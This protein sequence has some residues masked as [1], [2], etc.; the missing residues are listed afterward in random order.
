MAIHIL[1][2]NDL[3]EHEES[4]TCE[5]SPTLEIENGEMIFIHNS[6]D[7]RE[8]VESINKQ[9]QQPNINTNLISDGYHTFDEL[10]EH[11][12]TLWIALCKIIERTNEF[13]YVWRT[14]LHSDGSK[15][16]GW[17]VLGIGEDKGEQ[18]TYHLPIGKWNECSFAIPIDKA[19]EFDGH[20]SADVLK[21]ISTLF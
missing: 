21:R 4:S 19:P 18:M 9:I 20:T 13:S 16:D 15:F 6:Y 14:H 5:C 3:K 8:L 1:P 10:Y 7:G 2:I 11:R 17:F 12:C